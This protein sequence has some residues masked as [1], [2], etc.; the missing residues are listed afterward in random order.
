MSGPRF[1]PPAPPA[2]QLELPV[3]M[4]DWVREGTIDEAW[5]RFHLAHPEVYR[6][7]VALAREALHA[8]AERIGIGMI[9]EV[10]RWQHFMR[11]DPD[12]RFK[13]NNTYRSRYARLIMATE[14][15]LDGIFD[16]RSLRSP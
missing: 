5:W 9:Y 12:E 15:D 4:P 16:T 14:V 13:L 7:L 10:V 11:P 3:P 2:G 8:G 1:G 6:A